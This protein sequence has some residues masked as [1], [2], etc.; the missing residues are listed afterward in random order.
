MG[1]PGELLTMKV[2]SIDRCG[3]VVDVELAVDECVGVAPGLRAVIGC[4]ALEAVAVDG[5]M[6][7]WVDEDGIAAAKPVNAL[8]SLLA[9]GL[10]VPVRLRGTVVVTSADRE[11]GCAIDLTDIQVADVRRRLGARG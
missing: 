9:R 6:D 4:A 5:G 2:L 3:R 11:N 7:L 1:Y 10:G 8:A